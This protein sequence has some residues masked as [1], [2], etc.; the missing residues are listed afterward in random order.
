MNIALW[1]AQVLLAA[2]YGM[3]GFKKIFQTGKLRAQM[4]WA[5]DETPGSLRFVGASELLG[6]TGM[7]L[8]S[9][10]G[11]L[12]WLVPLVAV[13]LALIQLLAILTVHLPRNDYNILPLNV[14]L[15]ALSIFVAAGRWALIVSSFPFL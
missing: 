2:V 7:I 13:G 10:T 12:P 9:L 11:I 1:T 8:P 4:E 5:R 15:M 6:A 3:L 14:V